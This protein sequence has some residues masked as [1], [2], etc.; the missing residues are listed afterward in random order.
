MIKFINM[1]MASR[2]MDL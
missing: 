2:I 1:T